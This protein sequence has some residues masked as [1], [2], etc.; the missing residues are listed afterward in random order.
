MIRYKTLQTL[1]DAQTT[2]WNKISDAWAYA[3]ATTITVP[4]GATSLYSVGDKLK[5]TQTTVK[6]FYIT[7]VADTVLTILGGASYTL[8]NAAISAISVSKGNALG[9]PTSM[10]IPHSL[11]SGFTGTS[12]LEYDG[13]T[14]QVSWHFN[15][16]GTFNAGTHTAV[17][18][19]PAGYRPS[20]RYDVSSG[21]GVYSAGT[22]GA[23]G[24]FQINVKSDTGACNLWHPTGMSSPRGFIAWKR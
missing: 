24:W 2:G 6:Y 5:L 15:I 8:A 11:E 13:A 22:G 18:Y 10:T 17:I 3:S 19:I 9:F 7:A 12:V 1:L 20:S 16:A 14:D 21:N 4:A 23:S